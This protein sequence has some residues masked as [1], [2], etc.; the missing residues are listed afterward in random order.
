MLH[1]KHNLLPTSI[2]QLPSN[3]RIT[4]LNEKSRCR[5]EAEIMWF[6]ASVLI[7]QQLHTTSL[8]LGQEWLPLTY[9]KAAWR[10][11]G[12]TEGKK[13]KVG[14]GSFPWLFLKHRRWQ[15]EKVD[16]HRPD[17]VPL[18]EENIIENVIGYHINLSPNLLSM[19]TD[20]YIYIYLY[21]FLTHFII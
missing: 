2:F 16:L 4:L 12:H 8:C 18:S 9:W 20:I 21:S 5:S 3:C 14:Q 17:T 19:L 11:S 10:Y 13:K 15:W 1:D 7:H 6:A